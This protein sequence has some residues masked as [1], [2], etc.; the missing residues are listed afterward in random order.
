MWTRPGAE[1]FL[2][3]S[4]Q[5]LS[6]FQRRGAEFRSTLRS[7]EAK[8]SPDFH[9]RSQRA[10]RLIT[11]HPEQS[12]YVLVVPLCSLCDLLLKN[13]SLSF[14]AASCYPRLGSLPDFEIQGEFVALQ[15]H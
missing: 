4:R 2:G 1:T 5:S 11:E 10:Q 3:F 6:E 13:R 7:K 9:R 14:F 12:N 8:Q 15:E